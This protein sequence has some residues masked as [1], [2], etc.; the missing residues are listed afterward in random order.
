MLCCDKSSADFDFS[1]PFREFPQGWSADKFELGFIV[2]FVV[3]RY[4]AYPAKTYP[5]QD[6]AF[7]FEPHLVHICK[8][9]RDCGYGY[10]NGY[11]QC[12]IQLQLPL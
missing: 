9:H 1:T 11:D 7:S 5:S 6:F 10:E 4:R 12:H 8:Y 2:S 3:S